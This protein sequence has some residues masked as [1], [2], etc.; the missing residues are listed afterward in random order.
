MYLIQFMVKWL[1][2]KRIFLSAFPPDFVIEPNWLESILFSPSYA[3]RTDK[4]GFEFLC[5]NA[6]FNHEKKVKECK[7]TS[8]SFGSKNSKFLNLFH[9][10]YIYKI[11]GKICF[12]LVLLDFLFLFQKW[13]SIKLNQLACFLFI[14]FIEV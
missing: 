6:F 14:F 3:C 1:I 12:K 2:W 10:K 4:S 9:N 13:M 7:S 11:F 8:V 5:R